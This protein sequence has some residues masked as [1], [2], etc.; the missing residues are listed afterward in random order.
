MFKAFSL[1]S[2][3]SLVQSFFSFIVII[4]IT[5]Y[6]LE[7]Y[8]F[9][10]F[11]ILLLGSSFV[12]PLATSGCA[13][14]LGSNYYKNSNDENKKL[15]FN[16]LVFDFLLMTFWC[17][18]FYHISEILLNFILEFNKEYHLYFSLILLSI[19]SGVFW[20][21]I[22]TLLVMQEKP[23]IHISIEVFK[24]IINVTTVITC[25]TIFKVGLLSLI[26]GPLVSN[27]VFLVIEFSILT[28]SILV[29]WRVEE[30]VH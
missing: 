14:V 18:F 19:W 8:D 11:A 7:P 29:I 2:I 30:T 28:E 25:L 10:I 22:S 27:M 23:A 20:P 17:L 4:P 9:G 6:F 26:L 5:T 15:I 16:S 12:L 21:L 13:W 3:P 1:Y 24:W